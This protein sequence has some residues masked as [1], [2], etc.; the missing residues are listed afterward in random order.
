MPCWLAANTIAMALESD[1]GLE[2]LE[3][4]GLDGEQPDSDE[5]MAEAEKS[6]S[7]RGSKRG[8]E[9]SESA[10]SKG[11]G[12]GKGN[13]CLVVNGV[14]K[15]TKSHTRKCKNCLLYFRPEHMG[16]KSPYC[17]R[18][19]NRIDN[20]AKL[21]KQQGKAEWFKEIRCDSKKLAMVVKT[22][23]DMV[24]GDGVAGWKKAGCEAA[25]HVLLG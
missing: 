6:P 1:L 20:L 21:A 5:E 18:D 2:V 10:G 24:G 4:L 8:R 19:K 13:K 23:A 17:V 3:E 12:K 11:H 9:P 14:R 22:Y 16:A 15:A 25:D 7:Q